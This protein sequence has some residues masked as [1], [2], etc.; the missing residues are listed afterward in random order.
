MAS[1]A[2]GP[3]EQQA[4]SISSPQC[5]GPRLILS[6]SHIPE[7]RASSPNRSLASAINNAAAAASGRSRSSDHGHGG[8]PGAVFGGFLSWIFPAGAAHADDRKKKPESDQDARRHPA[9]RHQG[10][11]RHRHK[12][13]PVDRFRCVNVGVG[14]TAAQP[15]DDDVPREEAMSERERFE[16][17]LRQEREHQQRVGGARPCILPEAMR[18]QLEGLVRDHGGGASPRLLWW[19]ADRVERWYH[20]E[21]FA[22]ARVAR[23]GNPGSGE[24]AC[25]VQEGDITRVEYWF[26]DELG[27]AVNGNT[28]IPVI[29]R[30][31]PQ[32][33]R[34]GHIYNIGAA[35]QA[36]K[37]I[38]SLGL[39][40]SAELIPR[41]DEMK[42][43]GV[44]VEFQLRE[45]EPRS[46]GASI[47]PGGTVS[48]GH[49]NI[50]GLNRSLNDLSFN[51]EYEHPYLDGVE[52]R[53][54]NRAFKTSFF[55]TRKLS[56]VIVAGPSMEPVPP[57]WIDRVG[58]KANVTE[59][60]AQQSKF[61]Y[62]LV[63]EE[64][65]ARDENNNIRRHGW[66][67][68]P[69]G[70]LSMDGPPTT[71]SGTGVDRMAFL[72]ANMTRD[73]TE[74]VNGAAIGDR[75]IF[76][77]DQGL[78]IGSKNPFF[79]RHQLSVTKFIKLNNQEKGAGK[80]PPAV[81]ALHGRHAGCHRASIP[82]T[83]VDRYAQVYA[84]AE[85][86]TDLGSSKDV[87]GNPTE[88]FQRA[89]RGSSYGLGIKFGMIRAEFTMD[90]NIDT[91]SFSRR[92]RINEKPKALQMS[93]LEE[94]IDQEISNWVE[95]H[96]NEEDVATGDGAAVGKEGMAPVPPEL[97][98][99]MHYI[100]A[101]PTQ[102]P[103]LRPSGQQ[104]RPFQ[105]TQ[106]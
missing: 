65:T 16:R 68:L 6:S 99:Y 101:D 63:L 4:A 67:V 98:Q 75:C 38:K 41:P 83:V 104:S 21:G 10:A 17:D 66:R 1:D 47:K 37:H 24:L 93:Q 13:I 31:L 95:S 45:L 52:N 48:F 92:D 7:P 105:I 89:G 84:F 97:Q 61:T 64:I 79:N 26:L 56:P 55:N 34:P 87:E 39:F 23:F 106:A 33:L 81:L 80:P 88:F 69:T 3:P 74:F 9:A 71:F 30:E 49:R 28:H 72:Q 94:D 86:G 35:D 32:Q 62:G 20:G 57:L 77:V 27:N 60:F 51:F 12:V 53:S 85:H 25:E 103:P 44:V 100:T 70:R 90:H 46:A 29:E 78:G 43:G 15:H 59:K 102:M 11:A 18:E 14:R 36:V 91:G 54:R 50:S 76:Q 96:G 40:S 22:C 2:G 82:V 8:W 19:V 42:N 58:Y 5:S 73:N